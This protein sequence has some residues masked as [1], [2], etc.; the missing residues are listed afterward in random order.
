MATAGYLTAQR[1]IEMAYRDCGITQDT[2]Y[3]TASQYSDA[4]VRL[5]DLAN[6]W[7]TRGLKLW[8]VSDVAI[9]LVAGKATYTL[10]PSA[11]VNMA[12]PLRVIDAYNLDT[13]NIRRP[14][15]PLSWNDWTRLS[16]HTQMGQLNSYF[17]DKQQTAL[18][19]SFWLV[20]DAVAATNTA[21]LILQTQVTQMVNLTDNVGFP[22]EWAMALRWGLADD[23]A[24]G[25]PEAI[26]TRCERRAITFLQALEDWDVEDA[27]TMFTPDQRMLYSTSSFR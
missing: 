14:L 12:R 19:V 2:D 6:I 8:L 16:Q 21:H 17:V 20:P 18:N 24:T 1:I 7:Q 26:M 10:G 11:D 15:I 22:I 13:S 27:P 3:P 25:Q 23:L 4:L 9:D 5:N